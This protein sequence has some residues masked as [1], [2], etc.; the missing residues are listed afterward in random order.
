MDDSQESWREELD[1]RNDMGQEFSNEETDVGG[2]IRTHRE[3][4]TQLL[5]KCG[6]PLFPEGRIEWD[7]EGII[8][9]IRNILIGNLPVL[10]QN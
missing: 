2:E 5:R 1:T 7:K 9:L 6:M 3:R 10:H 8:T 4:A